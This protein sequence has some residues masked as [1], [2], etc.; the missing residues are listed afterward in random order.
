MDVCCKGKDIEYLYRINKYM[1]CVKAEWYWCHTQSLN[2]CITVCY[3]AVHI[4]INKEA[5]SVAPD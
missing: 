5:D 4:I 1:S 3:N 2:R